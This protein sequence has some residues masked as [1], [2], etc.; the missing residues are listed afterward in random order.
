MRGRVPAVPRLTY[1][2][3]WA[4][5]TGLGFVRESAR[6]QH[7]VFTHSPTETIIVLPHARGRDTVR[8]A[9]ILTTR[10]ML[11]GRGIASRQR[12]ESMVN[13]KTEI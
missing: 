9:T 10:V 7:V 11:E 12:W 2:R 1:S 4:I 3:L 6:G 5:L 13:S 8:A